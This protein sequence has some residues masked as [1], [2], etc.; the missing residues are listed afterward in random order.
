[1]NALNSLEYRK[2]FSNYLR[3]GTPIGL[4]LKAG[5][6]GHPT[7][8]YIWRTRGDP[9]VRRSHMENNGKVFPWDNPPETGHPGEDYNCRCIAEPYERGDSEYAYQTVISDINDNPKQWNTWNFIDHFRNGGGRPVTL[10]E[11]G[12]LAGLIFQYFYPALVIDRINAQII[13]AARRVKSGPVSYDFDGTY[14]FIDYVFAFGKGVIRGLFSGSVRTENGMM[15]IEGDIVYEYS[16]RFTDPL[17]LREI[18]TGSSALTPQSWQFT[19]L[20]GTAYDITDTWTTRF[21]AEAKL[22]SDKSIYR[23]LE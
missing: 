20:D 13:D 16:D 11:T 21:R 8:H 17:D 12:N 5:D 2:A 4:S 22:D 10:S 23:W 6:L 9:Q 19:E 3:W 7:T 18:A 1:M 14:Q 15:Y